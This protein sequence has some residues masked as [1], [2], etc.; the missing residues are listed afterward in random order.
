MFIQTDT[1]PNP[2]ALK[3]IP[4]LD[5]AESPVY[6]LTEKDAHNSFLARKILAIK[7]VETV[8]FGTDFITVSKKEDGNWDVLKPEILMMIMDHFTSGLSAFDFVQ[9]QLKPSS[10]T[11][12]DSE[13]ERQIIEIIETRVRPSVAM[14][15]GDII[16]KSFEDGVVKLELHG[17]C[18]GCPSS[19]ITLKNGIESMLKHYVPEV[20]SVEAINN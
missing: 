9:E 20:K 18:S 8:F 14:D 13:I 3:F 2:N 12:Y 7:F 1:T 16:Y 6:F 5:V 11:N 19:T 4:G 10:K 15:G 17:A